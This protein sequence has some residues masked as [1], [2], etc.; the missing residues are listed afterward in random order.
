MNDILWLVYLAN[1]VGNLNS[2][3]CAFLAIGWSV[4]G[5]AIFMYGLHYE[6]LLPKAARYATGLLGAMRHARVE[7]AA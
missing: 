4:F 2:T 7:E 3:L 6:K 5:I 1:V